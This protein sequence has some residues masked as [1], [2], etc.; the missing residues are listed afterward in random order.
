LVSLEIERVLIWLF[1]HE[2][3]DGVLCKGILL[4]PLPFLVVVREACRGDVAKLNDFSRQRA[5]TEWQGRE[6]C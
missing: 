1:G 5:L 2:K 4:P 3:N 6:L